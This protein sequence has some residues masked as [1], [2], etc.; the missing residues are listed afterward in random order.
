MATEDAAGEGRK[1]IALIGH[2]PQKMFLAELEKHGDLW[3][4]GQKLVEFFFVKAKINKYNHVDKGSDRLQLFWHILLVLMTKRKQVMCNVAAVG[5]KHRALCNEKKERKENVCF[6]N[7]PIAHSHKP[8]P[9]P[10]C[11]THSNDCK[12][13]LK[14]LTS[15]SKTRK[16][17]K[18]QQTRG[19]ER[20]TGRTCRGWRKRAVRLQR[21]S[22]PKP[23]P[24]ASCTT[25]QQT[26]APS[27]SPG[28]SATA[29]TRA[30]EMVI[31]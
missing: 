25:A 12:A 26:H 23:C 13:K 20:E 31:L 18:L 6:L 3:R 8:P 16:P 22:Q 1:A 24:P 19:E 2:Y 11:R 15:Q 5:E 4:T 29:H 28:W 21:E 9:D 7:L 14:R 30:M 17:Q 10:D 27:C